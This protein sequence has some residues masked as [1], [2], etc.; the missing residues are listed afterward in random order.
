MHEAIRFLLSVWSEQPGEFFC[1]ATK[2]K[3]GG[4]WK[5]HLF[6]W[7]IDEDTLEEFFD[8]HST[9]HYNLYFCPHGF[10]QKKR[11]KEYAANTVFL[12]ADL[13]EKQPGKCA[14]VPQI[15]W[16]TSPGRYAALWR[17]TSEQEASDIEEV[18][19]ALSYKNGADHG[20]WDL[21][22]VLRI[23]GTRNHKYP[24]SPRGKLLWH[25]SNAYSLKDLPEPS[26]PNTD[27]EDAGDADMDEVLEKWKGK[28]KKDTL[29]L[30]TAKAATQGVRSD[31]IWK[32]ENE[33]HE[34]GL[35]FEEIF[36]LIKNSVWNKFN[37]RRGEDRQ[38]RRELTKV[39]RRHEK[40]NGHATPLA[41]HDAGKPSQPAKLI[42]LSDVEAEEV[43]WLWWPYIAYGKVTIVE[44]DPGLGK[45]WFTT[46]LCSYVSK[47]E[48]LP[49]QK[50]DAVSGG[51]L[52]MSAEDGLG[53]TIRPRLDTL[54]ANH[55]RIFAVDG[56]VTLDED[57]D[58]EIRGYIER[59][60][61]KILIMDPLVAYLG[62][63]V[64][65]HKANETREVMARLARIASDFHIA[66]IVVRHLTKGSR[67]K[68]IYRGI[69]S[70]DLTAAARSV[71]IVGRNPEDP[72]EGRVVCHIKNN[73]GP[74]GRPQSYS[75]RSSRS[76]PFTFDGPVNFTAEEIF[77]AEATGNPSSWEVVCAFLEQSLKN[78]PRW[79]D[80]VRRDAEAKGFDSKTVNQAKKEVG[81]VTTTVGERVKW[82][83][84][85]KS[86]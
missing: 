46:A 5:E 39:H 41:G 34:T 38:L 18:N 7:P 25:K 73:L 49:G 62:G 64:D 78:G 80:E 65:L 67:D 23:P 53:D 10:S 55:R 76:R 82:S 52:L 20:G 86:S 71:L 35:S 69:G 6:K 74:L 77:K 13:D 28:I 42:R 14:P 45:S 37:G 48:K 29:R 79:A 21:T 26:D 8:G 30:L 17:L 22:Q 83:W 33:L 4:D 58:E 59:V 9:D 72:D 54:N 12:W 19:R 63:K 51:V 3:K 11:R 68:S 75:L 2:S 40:V 32:L 60:R 16:Q 70:I 31:M 84:P 85:K 44:G 57:G 43:D 24:S 81:I 47:G 1:L 15:A 36:V 61:P 56:L 27:N 66:A 50:G